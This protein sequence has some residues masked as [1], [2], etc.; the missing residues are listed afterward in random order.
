MIDGTPHELE[1]IRS[2]YAP[3]TIQFGS[4]FDYHPQAHLAK[5]ETMT[6][7]RIFYVYQD[8]N[9]GEKIHIREGPNA[10][11]NALIKDLTAREIIELLRKPTLYRL[12]PNDLLDYKYQELIDMTLQSFLD[13]DRKKARR[14]QYAR[15]LLQHWWLQIK[16]KP[17][18]KIE[19]STFI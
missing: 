12:F 16:G 9:T 19:T 13:K 17:P 7:D 11:V 3:T 10:R 8:N 14:Y 6:L 18:L 2:S 5:T 1:E 15:R 4:K